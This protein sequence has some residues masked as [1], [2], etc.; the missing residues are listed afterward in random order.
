MYVLATQKT[1][2]TLPHAI[3]TVTMLI[4]SFYRKQRSVPKDQYSYSAFY[5]VWLAG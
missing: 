3:A 4:Y 1:K 2:I 5:E